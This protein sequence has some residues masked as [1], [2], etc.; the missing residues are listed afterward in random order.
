MKKLLLYV[1]VWLVCYAASAQTITAYRYW[2]D[3][4]FTNA[5]IVNGSFGANYFLDNQFSVS[6]LA[7]GLHSFNIAFKESSSKWSSTSSS[8]FYKQTSTA[9][10]GQAQYQYWFDNNFSN[11]STTP[12]TSNNDFYL[13][14]DL[15][16]NSLSN[17]LHSLNI[18]FRPDGGTWSVVTSSFFYKSS[19]SSTSSITKYQ[20]W[21]DNKVQDSVSVNVTPTSNLDL[22]TDINAGSLTN[23]LHVFN[24]RFKQADG[25]WS[26]VKSDF[27]YKANVTNSNVNSLTQMRYW[28]DANRSFYRELAVG[29]Q[30]TIADLL[31]PLDVDG[32]TLGKHY[33]YTQFG[34]AAGTYSSILIDSF[35]KTPT[36]IRTYLFPK[37]QFVSSTIIAGNLLNVSGNDFT[38][39]GLIEV[40]MLNSLSVQVTDTL[41][42]A[43]G[44][45]K[46]NIQYAKTNVASGEYL[47]TGFDRTTYYNSDARRI[48]ILNN[49][50]TSASGLHVT[51]PKVQGNE[52]AGEK[53]NISWNDYGDGNLVPI[54]NTAKALVNYKIE[55]RYNNGTWQTAGI[56]G[57][58]ILI[59]QNNSFSVEHTLGDEGD[60]QFRVSRVNEP[61]RIDYS[62]SIYVGFL[63]VGSLVTT[64]WDSSGIRMPQG[65]VGACADGA[66]RF[67]FKVSKSNTNT[68]TIVTVQCALKDGNILEPRLLGKLS[69]A[70]TI[71]GYT[72]E[73]NTATQISV[74]RAS[75]NA[76]GN[77]WFWYVAPDD[78]AR[79]LPDNFLAERTV[80]AEFTIQYSNGTIDIIKKDIKIIRP[81][82][83]L[84]HG[85]N[86]DP[87]TWDNF[88]FTESGYTYKFREAHR[89]NVLYKFPV[90][91][92]EMDKGGSF[93]TNAQTLLNLTP[94]NK[95]RPTRI[96]TLTNSLQNCINDYR[97]NRFA[98]N[99]VD[100]TGH[101]MGGLMAR[102]AINI[103]N[104]YYNPSP[105]ENVLYKNYGKGF[106][107]KLITINT[108]H[109]G[110]PFADMGADNFDN[111]LVQTVLQGLNFTKPTR[112][113]LSGLFVFDNSRFIP[114]VYPTNAMYDLRGVYGGIRFKQTNVKNHLIGGDMDI[115]TQDCNFKLKEVIKHA[116]ISTPKVFTATKALIDFFEFQNQLR[117]VGLVAI[118][119]FVIENAIEGALID[120]NKYIWKENVVNG[121]CYGVDKIIDE[122]YGMPN[123]INR[124]DL[125][126][127]V[128]SQLPGISL[129]LPLPSYATLL[130]GVESMHINVTS[131][132][133]AGDKV[134]DLIN[135][136]VNSPSFRDF[137][138]ESPN[139]ASGISYRTAQNL[140][141]VIQILD[142]IKMK[143]VAPQ[144]NSVITND[145]SFNVTLNLK[146]TVGL[147]TISGRYL[148][149]QFLSYSNAK[150]QTFTIPINNEVSGKHKVYAIATYDS[151]RFIVHHMDT[152]IINIPF[153]NNFIRLYAEPSAINLST[154]QSVMPDIYGVSDSTYK[155]IPL[156]DPSL[157]I[158][159][160][161]TNV[162]RFSSNSW[163]FTAKDSGTTFASL[164]YH[165]R[166]DTV[167]FF[168][169]LPDESGIYACPGGNTIFK[170]D[171]GIVGDSYQWQVDMG[172]GFENISN[173]SIYFGATSNILI[174]SNPPTS[175]YGYK[176][177]CIVTSGSIVSSS[178]TS[179]LYF[180]MQWIGATNTAWENPENWNCNS[181]PDENVEVTI[182]KGLP[183]NPVISSNPSVKS[184]K[185]SQGANL[186]VSSGFN[187]QIKGLPDTN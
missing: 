4:A 64:V 19:G 66:A 39:H 169:S 130:H 61:G 71:S 16:V 157:Q 185:L 86:S 75:Q 171:I 62:A 137:I 135:R 98:C 182:P 110:T 151:S 21:F 47:I 122:K 58:N 141:S 155:L 148:D 73:A 128:E 42:Y 22:T 133:Q 95:P 41:V 67:Y 38:P 174:L 8:F 113:A 162:V 145:T 179:V 177:R 159:V 119:N 167:Y 85:I 181:L 101:S 20:Y 93:L 81:P 65:P 134:L 123:F 37:I 32:L 11:A 154:G 146:D 7:D 80:V 53:I 24:M 84:V 36:G 143:I 99:R 175:W 120:I 74:T 184:L 17:G 46:F 139:Q 121:L 132:I 176:Y 127:P 117:K 125:V 111:I 164:S 72:L 131:N 114:D 6:Q 68:R 187:L 170:S 100:Y 94:E 97:M 166:K 76:D 178:K 56:V 104:K 33:F 183:N 90:R 91:A 79:D 105:T 165:G 109:N 70:N 158:N 45:G 35:V 54:G 59:K 44:S 136:P 82:L 29:Q 124:S 161:D 116:Q 57:R 186:K 142:T 108:P 18:R 49:T 2:Y 23:G 160:S 12:I 126:V 77:Y 27:F 87:S 102:T 92:L 103:F 1:L 153:N 163:Q 15:N 147:I 34:D 107:N 10:A 115:G 28:F 150:E 52:Q 106:I 89:F 55:K 173:N 78:F 3:N 168:V 31:L 9:T 51:S 25:L 50:V 26:V 63:S 48:K 140:D 138:P 5:T 69:L 30:G 40:R 88:R 43:D 14:A 144:N 129:T 152:V 172:S 83:V 112:D 13:I 96:A 156:K 118:K 60:Y 180:A 149:R